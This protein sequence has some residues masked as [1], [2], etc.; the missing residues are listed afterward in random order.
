[1]DVDQPRNDVGTL[2]SNRFKPFASIAYEAANLI[3]EYLTDPDDTWASTD[4]AS[5]LT[6]PGV[7]VLAARSC[8]S[9]QTPQYAPVRHLQD[10]ISSLPSS[11][12]S[13]F[14]GTFGTVA[15]AL[16]VQATV[17]EPRLNSTVRSGVRWLS[18]RLDVAMR[19]RAEG[20]VP[21]REYDSITGL[22]GMG[23]VLLFAQTQG[24]SMAEPGLRSALEMATVLLRR[25]EIPAWWQPPHEP[26][27]GRP[28]PFGIDRIS[29]SALLGMAHGVA[30]PLAF[31][32]VAMKAGLEVDGQREA[33]RDAT[34]W[35]LGWRD[36]QDRLWPVGV[37]GR[38]LRDRRPNSD[39]H[40]KG[41]QWCVGMV[42]IAQ[43][44]H[45]AGLAL[46]DRGT[47]DHGIEALATLGG[48]PSSEW[49]VNGPAICCGYAGVLQT[50]L[51][52]ASTTPD[53]RL[54]A[55]ADAAAEKILER[56]DAEQPSRLIR[57]RGA[58]QP[59]D[60]TILTGMSGIGLA[61]YDY[62]CG[63]SLWSSLLLVQ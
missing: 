61:L 51:V 29:G 10:A 52:A 32:S 40:P 23:R 47:V 5:W 7:A 6:S 53:E 38:E 46:H 54:D 18:D 15:A 4:S 20:A 11:Q 12:D 59:L 33:I 25:G 56:W 58:R 35:I 13:I 2:A 1:M 50:V 27:D 55:V 26:S 39:P 42:G 43:A 3:A 19:A 45:L 14:C 8:G 49:A 62:A 57:A 28:P 34:D 16:V 17:E 36:Q 41:H 60:A 44:L 22:A 9:A 48:L 37:T 30:G 63:P 24:Q 31:L 21:V